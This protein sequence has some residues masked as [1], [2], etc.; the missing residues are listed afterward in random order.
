MRWKP[1]IMHEAMHLKKEEAGTLKMLVAT[2]K[3]PGNEDTWTEC[4]TVYDKAGSL[5][6]VPW[7]Q[8]PPEHCVSRQQAMGQAVQNC[9]PVGGDNRF[10]SPERPHQHWTA[11]RK[12]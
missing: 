12:G 6:S 3:M 9:I 7:T 10:S 4:V 5:V 1:Q 2:C 11:T 8:Q